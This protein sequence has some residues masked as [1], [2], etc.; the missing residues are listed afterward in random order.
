MHSARAEKESMT[1]IAVASITAPLTQNLATFSASSSWTD[2]S[3]RSAV[4]DSR[5]ATDMDQ[6]GVPLSDSERRSS[7]T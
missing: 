7:A 4:V 5:V 2:L 6:S 3:S 1:S